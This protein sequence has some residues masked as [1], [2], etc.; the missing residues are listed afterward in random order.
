MA[1][2]HILLAIAGMSRSECDSTD[3]SRETNARD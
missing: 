3:A 1:D 2:A